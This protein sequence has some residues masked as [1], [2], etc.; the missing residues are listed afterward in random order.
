MRTDSSLF[1]HQISGN[2]LRGRIECWHPDSPGGRVEVT[3][4]FPGLRR[5]PFATLR[6]MLRDDMEYR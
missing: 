4:W 5:N 3:R 6:E 1:E 2:W